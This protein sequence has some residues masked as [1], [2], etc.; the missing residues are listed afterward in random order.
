M[1]KSSTQEPTSTETR[2]RDSLKER[3]L[4]EYRNHLEAELKDVERQLE[5]LAS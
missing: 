5:E 1:A 3:V 2:E 4:R